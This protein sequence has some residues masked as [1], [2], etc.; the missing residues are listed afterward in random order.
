MSP[1]L[2]RRI[3]GESCRNRGRLRRLPF[4]TSALFGLPVSPLERSL[5]M[6][7]DVG[8]DCL[9]SSVSTGPG[10]HWYLDR[11]KRNAAR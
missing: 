10:R 11:E 5:R 8:D 1:E 9:S 6:P 2:K 7:L 4:R 3:F